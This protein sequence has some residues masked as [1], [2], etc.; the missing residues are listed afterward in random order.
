MPYKIQSKIVG[1]CCTHHCILRP[2]CTIVI[3]DHPIIYNVG[4]VYQV[5]APLSIL[6]KTDGGDGDDVESDERVDHQLSSLATV[7]SDAALNHA[8]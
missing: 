3:T 4:H 7:I 2:I 5:Q 8:L 1:E 6:K